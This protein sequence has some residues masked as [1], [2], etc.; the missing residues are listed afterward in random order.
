MSKVDR[1][2][3]G[4]H[5]LV[6]GDH[7]QNPPCRSLVPRW[8]L[9][10]VL[11]ALSKKLFEPLHQPMPWDL[12]LKVLFLLAATFAHRVS[13]IHA[14]CINPPFLIQNPQVFSSG[15]ESSVLA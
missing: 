4:R 5:P 10:V 15:T 6:L 11:A 2:L 12:M 1:I 13:E 14:L 9:S 7:A 8:N 3:V